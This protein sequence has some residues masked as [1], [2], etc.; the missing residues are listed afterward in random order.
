MA[1]RGPRKR[2]QESPTKP[3]A[4]RKQLESELERE[5]KTLK[6]GERVRF[7]WEGLIRM[8]RFAAFSTPRSPLGAESVVEKGEAWIAVK[9]KQQVRVPLT[10][11]E[12][13]VVG[14]QRE[15]TH[16]WA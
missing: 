15:A 10:R 11:V 12:R 1:L 9:T 6:P 14:K 13:V 4:R 3:R 2:G 8:G 16:G 5:A 7:L